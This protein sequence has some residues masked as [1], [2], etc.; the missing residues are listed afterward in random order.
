MKIGLIKRKYLVL[1][2]F[3]F[4]AIYMMKREVLLIF[5][6]LDFFTLQDCDYASCQ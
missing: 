2:I 5:N 6:R 1:W 4:V 3:E